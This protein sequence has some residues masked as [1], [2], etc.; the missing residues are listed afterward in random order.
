MLNALSRWPVSTRNVG[1][2]VQGF[3]ARMLSAGSS[4]TTQFATVQ[5]NLQAIHLFVV[6]PFHLFHRSR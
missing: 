1:I 3:A 6:N 4:I 2:L 5:G